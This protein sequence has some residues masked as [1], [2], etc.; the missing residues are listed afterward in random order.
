MAGYF[1]IRGYLTKVDHPTLGV[2]TVVGPTTTYSETPALS[3][4][5]A[6]GLGQEVLI[7]VLGFDGRKYRRCAMIT[8]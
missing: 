4:G 8:S 6:P 3:P 7:S 1:S 5:I 2:R